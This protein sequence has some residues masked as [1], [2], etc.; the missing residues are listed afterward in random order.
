MTPSTS[1]TTQL[2]HFFVH[3]RLHYQ[4]FILSGGYL[5][6]SLFLEQVEWTLFSL[7][8]LNVHILLFG[9]ATA[10]NSYWDKDEGPIGGLKNPPKMT[11]WMWV[12]SMGMQWAGLA[13]ALSVGMS[14]AIIYLVSLILFWLYSTPVARW[15][16]NPFLSLFAIGISTGTNSFLLGFLAGGGGS[17]SVTE[18]FIAFGVACI[19]LSLYPAS[20]IY[21][22]KEDK[23]RGD[24][25]FAMKFGLSGVR[26]FYTIMF[27][28]G[29]WIIASFLY[30][31]NPILGLI[32]GGL[33]ML[34]FS[35]VS[36]ILF[37]LKGKQE[38]YGLVMK[39][40]FLAS[41]SFVAFILS[42][43]L[44]KSMI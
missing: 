40:K 1:L 44:I 2:W 22:M 31:T 3:L 42:T 29:T 4:F 41:F 34:A 6:S 19:I 16:G 38:E 39:I 35:G 12:V 23:A 11:R 13:W 25:T 14:F 33:G 37:K 10:Y 24:H 28:T 27:L 43:L 5:L 8:F 15:K 21:Q 20:Q 7:Q 32:F 30:K 18:G 17:L 26:V 9:G 36:I